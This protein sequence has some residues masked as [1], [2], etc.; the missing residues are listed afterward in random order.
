MPDETTI[1]KDEEESVKRVY[2]AFGVAVHTAQLVEKELALVLLLPSHTGAKRLPS[3]DEISKTK[4]EVDRLTFGQLLRRLKKVATISPEFEKALDDG[5]KKR[6]YLIHNFFDSYG[7]NIWISST[8]EKMIADL[9]TIHNALHS[10]YKTF[11][12]LSYESFKA[13]G[14]TDEQIQAKIDQLETD[15]SAKRRES[16]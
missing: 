1:T 7:A 16:V 10:V 3:A 8:R 12:E 9:G 4:E 11:S 6:N 5:L 15:F 14:M 13:W 2:V